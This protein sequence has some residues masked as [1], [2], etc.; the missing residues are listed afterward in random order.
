MQRA[1]KATW[2]FSCKRSGFEWM[3][4]TDC[5]H[6]LFISRYAFG[7]LFGTSLDRS[8]AIDTLYCLKNLLP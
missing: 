3:V 8:A 5:Y 6:A 1:K 7:A 4:C 2:I